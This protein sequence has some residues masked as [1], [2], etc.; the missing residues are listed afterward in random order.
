MLVF[1]YFFLCVV[2]SG[3]TISLDVDVVIVGG[4]T[5]GCVLAARLCTRLPSFK[6]ALLERSLPRDPHSEFLVRAPRNAFDAWISPE[7]VEK[8]KS[9]PNLGLNNRSVEII[10]GNTIGGS[11]AVNAMQYTI[12]AGG[13]IKDWGITG[14]DRRM[15]NRYYRKAFRTLRVA[16]QNDG[17]QQV[18]ANDVVEAA[19][20]AGFFNISSPFR[21]RPRKTVSKTL[22][23]IDE[24]G[25]RIDSYTAYLLPAIQGPCKHNLRLIQGATVSKILLDEDGQTAVGVQYL[26]TNEGNNSPTTSIRASKE[27]ILASG[28]IG[29]PKLLQLSGI[30]PAKTLSKSGIRTIVDLPVGMK[31]MGH[32]TAIYIS[33]FSGVPVEP[34]NDPSLVKENMRRQFENGNGGVFGTGIIAVSYED[35]RAGYGAAFMVDSVGGEGLGFS[36]L[37]S[38]CFGNAISNGNL[39]LKD[40]N[41][42]SS[43]DIQLNLLGDNLDVKN[44][45]KCIRAYKNVHHQ[46]DERFNAKVVAPEGNTLNEGALRQTAGAGFHYV[47]TCAVGSVVDGTLHVKGVKKLRVV[48]SSILN[49]LP[50]SAGL[51]SSIFM[52]SEYA[53]EMIVRKYSSQNSNKDSR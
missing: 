1:F 52:V 18:Y 37:F 11:S 50:T 51:A 47:G 33:A 12:P 35:K 34:A 27:V 40:A 41:P 20:R 3:T 49:T 38:I 21:R 28:A 6:I 32:A 4:G 14:L 17:R 9:K 36:G 24:K 10:T 15:A 26:H 16:Q 22:T 30:G 53:S 7:V 29:S 31:I 45:L 44:L 48:D 5:A 39:H 42:F 25:Q 19:T 8:F 13:V 23:S 46:L 43:P 2:L